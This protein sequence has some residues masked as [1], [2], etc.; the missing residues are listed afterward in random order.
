MI[1]LTELLMQ[2]ETFRTT[3]ARRDARLHGQ[4]FPATNELLGTYPGADGVKTGSTTQGGYSVVAS[5]TR[6]GR[7]IAVAVLGSPTDAGRFDAAADL[8]DWA[9]TH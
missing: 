7:S 2:D 6:E 9:F 4:V 3:V 1:D 5:A 8:L